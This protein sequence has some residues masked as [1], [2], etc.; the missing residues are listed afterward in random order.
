MRRGM[1]NKF[2]LVK[3]GNRPCC[4]GKDVAEREETF[5]DIVHQ[6]GQ[7]Y[8]FTFSEYREMKTSELLELYNRFCADIAKQNRST[9]RG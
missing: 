8:S 1:F 6:L 4:L 3:I 9:N 7:F 5:F 2:F